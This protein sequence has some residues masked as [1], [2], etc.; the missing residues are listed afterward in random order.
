V[1][2]SFTSILL[3]TA[4]IVGAQ[5]PAAI[6][7][8]AQLP[9]AVVGTL[10]TTP[11]PLAASTN[12]VAASRDV[13]VRITSPLGRT[14]TPGLVGIVAQVQARNNADIGPVRFM[15]DGPL[16][17]TVAAGPP[18][19]VQWYDDNPFQARRI[20][21]EVPDREGRV[22]QGEDEPGLA[23]RCIHVPVFEMTW[24]VKKRR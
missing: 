10:G 3:A 21:V 8:V 18:F 14:G 11:P 20:E 6:T 17:D 1:I 16:L 19:A 2:A 24:P 9:P 23:T 13:S 15:V 5:G 7:P 4:A 22:R 12:G